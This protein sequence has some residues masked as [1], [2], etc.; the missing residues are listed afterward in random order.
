VFVHRTTGPAEFWF[1]E[2]A[3]GDVTD[4]AVL[5]NLR[6]ELG[7]DAIATMRQVHGSDVAW[8]MPGLVPEADALLTYTP[9]LGVLARVAD[10]VPIVMATQQRDAI[11][12]V[13]AGRKGL[14][15]GVA[16]AAARIL[17]ERGKGTVSAWIGP[18]ICGRC[19]ELDVE[20]AAAVIEAVPAAASTTSWGTP[21]AD[22]GAGVAA[23]L[24]SLGLDV[25][26]VGGCTLEDDRFFSYRR[27]G[28][29]QRQGAIVVLR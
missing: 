28:T 27:D 22:I 23:Q 8:A 11:G 24:V 12:V 1:T 19:Y 4:P 3:D 21:A 17:Q 10:C 14:V 15:A 20:T 13:H 7:L 6:S 25:T 18:R 29:A 2:A 5:A 26:D 9:E 16:P